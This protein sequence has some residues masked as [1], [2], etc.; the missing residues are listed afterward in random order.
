M[1]KDFSP[2]NW[3]QISDYLDGKC[4]NKDR[5]IV[6]ELIN[7][8]EIWKSNY[9]SLANLRAL[10]RAAPRRR[11]PRNFVLTQSQADQIRK[12][13]WTFLSFRFASALST[14]MAI[15]VFLFSFLMQSPLTNRSALPAAPALDKVS[16]TESVEATQGSPIIVWGPPGTNPQLSQNYGYGG[17]GG[18]AMPLGKG[19]GGAG[20][21][22]IGGGAPEP[23]GVEAPAGVT[24]TETAPDAASDS[25]SEPAPEIGS[26]AT[27]E[28]A[29]AFAAEP[30]PEIA[31]ELAPSGPG[32]TTMPTQI[33]MPAPAPTAES[34]RLREGAPD[35]TGSGPI[36][37][38]NPT[39]LSVE[40]AQPPV[41]VEQP[42]ALPNRAPFWIAS[43]ILLVIGI[44]T[45]LAALFKSGKKHA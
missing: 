4:S 29:S 11:A 14:G 25:I 30:A 38:V 16:Q 12:P 15:A 7:T 5:Q 34:Q 31:P 13:V 28:A 39:A 18:G 6:E 33:P 37:G 1:S 8:S 41:P 32:M 23:F 43:G 36:L 21:S 24:P 22:G 17:G 3:Q 2:Q 40:L 9:Q 44:L 20:G 35:I 10:L 19:G 45:G 27:P 26:T 42:R